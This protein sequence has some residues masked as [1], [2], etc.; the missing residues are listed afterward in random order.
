MEYIDH[1][2]PAPRISRSFTRAHLV[3]L[4]LPEPWRP[5]EILYRWL[6]RKAWWSRI[7]R[8]WSPRLSFQELPRVPTIEEM[9]FVDPWGN[10]RSR[11][12]FPEQ[13]PADAG[14]ALWMRHPQFGTRTGINLDDIP[15][16]RRGHSHPGQRKKRTLCSLWRF[17]KDGV[18]TYLP[19]CQKVLAESSK[20]SRARCSLRARRAAHHAQRRPHHQED[21]RRQRS[22][23]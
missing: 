22:F 4:P 14:T 5:G 3:K 16:E 21:C 6:A 23:P 9:N 19:E 12:A 2:D 20:H 8:S 7:R 15:F 17:S 13:R 1:F 10:A 11:A 18:V